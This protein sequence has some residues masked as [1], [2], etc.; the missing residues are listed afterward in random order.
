MSRQLT[1]RGV[2][3]DVA[4]RLERLSRARG[5]R[6]KATVNEILLEALGED[7]RR[8]QLQAMAT[9]SPDEVRAFNQAVASLR[10]VDD[11][12]WR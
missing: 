1:I 5:R 6:V 3:D 9:W 2:P 7:A 8:R 12:L 11:D 10:D 4:Q